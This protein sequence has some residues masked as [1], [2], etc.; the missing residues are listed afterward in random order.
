M[1]KFDQHRGIVLPLI[2]DNIDTDQII[3][4]REMKKVSKLGLAEGLFSGQRYLYEGDKKIGENPEFILNTPPYSESTILLSGKN[5]GCGSSREHAVWAL[6]EYG[7]KA[8]IAES[9]G[10]IF[11]SNCLRNGLL[12][13]KL[14]AGDIENILEQLGSDPI[15][16]QLVVDLQSR[17]V[18]APNGEKFDF[19]LEDYY[20]KM[21]IN[22]WDFID[23][24]LQFSEQIDSFIE[25]DK[26]QRSWAY[27]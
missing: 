2:G 8:V 18:I 9:F 12:P 22:G 27:L 1:N 13:I 14:L 17:Q 6:I 16:Q 11:R 5:F 21:L 15:A 4:S 10:D 25:S 19:D 26:Q 20:Q 7:F 3:P 24:A 23:L